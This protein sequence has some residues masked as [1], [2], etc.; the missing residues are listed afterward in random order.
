MMRITTMLKKNWFLWLTGL[1][2]LGLSGLVV[3]TAVAQSDIITAEV[4]RTTVSTDETVQLTITVNEYGAGQPDLPALEGFS[5]VGTSSATQMSLINGAMSVQAVYQYRL[6]PYEVGTLTIPA[7]SVSANGY[8]YSSEPLTVEVVQGQTQPNLPNTAGDSDIIPPADELV[9]QDF[10]VEASVGNE[11]PYLGEQVTYYF[12]FYQAVDLMGQPSYEAPEFAGFWSDTDAQQTSQLV[13]AA[14]RTYRVT[15]LQTAIFPTLVGEQTI[16]PA[17]LTLPGSLFSRGQTMAT[18]QVMVNV[19][20]HPGPSPAGFTGAV[21]QLTMRSEVDN[22]AVDINDAVTLRVTVSG[23]G[24]MAT[25]PE[26]VWPEWDGWREFETTSEHRVGV[27]N[28]RVAG[29]KVFE[30]LLIPIETGSQTLPS[31]SYTYFDPTTETYVTET[32]DPIAVTVAGNVPSVA[33][34]RVAPADSDG[35]DMANETTAVL[36]I[37]SVP[38]T[39]NTTA[40][41]GLSGAASV[42]AFLNSPLFWLMALLPALVLAGDWGYS[43]Y[44]KQLAKDPAALRRRRA[45]CTAV[46]QLKQASTP[47]QIAQIVTRYLGHRLNEPTTGMTRSALSKTLHTAGLDDTLIGRVQELLTL[48]E[49]AE[50]APQATGELNLVNEAVELIGLIEKETSN[51]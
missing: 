21:G 2:A 20:P 32:S 17:T 28:G 30:K 39:L 6:Q 50:F 37:K 44:Q 4:D 1:L 10:Y 35:Q 29:E 7:V 31:V 42:T 5:I 46:K 19:R 22:T 43:A 8:S 36:P 38:E 14:G 51:Q 41:S 3:N 25:L 40:V 47:T 18:K 24:N 15:E 27:D 12:R 48:C 49:A 16:N 9:G 34:D 11:T 26:P 45:K 23:K 33:A 13:Q